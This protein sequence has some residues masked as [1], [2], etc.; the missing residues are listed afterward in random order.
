MTTTTLS[1]RYPGATIA[2]G[3][4]I[5]ETCRI[6]PGAQI[7]AQAVLDPAVVIC[8][9]VK[10][11][12]QVHLARAVNVREKATLVG[13]LHISENTYIARDAKIGLEHA[14][15]ATPTPVTHIGAEILFGVQVGDHARVRAG[16]RLIGDLPQYG[17]A[18]HAPA[19]LERYACPHCGG[20]LRVI[21]SFREIVDTRC[22]Q[23]GF[24]T[25]RFSKHRFASIFSR[26][27][28]PGNTFGE[29][30]NTRGDDPRWIDEKELQ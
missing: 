1:T 18:S 13:P 24:G 17:L 7:S 9:N 28:L 27:L 22:N 2:E 12:G 8:Q 15:S 26:V 5:H 3:A 29:L 19:I 10:I 11:I 4:T 6:D 30:V 23:C 21:R 20:P 16:S 25:L 14:E